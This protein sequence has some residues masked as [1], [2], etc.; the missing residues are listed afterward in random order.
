MQQTLNKASS[1]HVISHHQFA[2]VRINSVTKQKSLYATRA[3]NKGD[4]I[5]SFN[6]GQIFNEPNYLTVQTD[7]EKHITLQPEFLQYINHSCAP[8][9]FFNTTTMQL[10]CIENVSIEEEFSFFYPSTEWH[11]AQSFFCYCGASNCL[12][13]IRGAKFLTPE[14]LKKYDFTD[15]IISLL[16]PTVL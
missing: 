15:F 11:M 1:T 8:N 12:Q 13:N 7:V 14:Q 4:I 9:A 2:E 3:F 16:K 10:I 6:A 5:S